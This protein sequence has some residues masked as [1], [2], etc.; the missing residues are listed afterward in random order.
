MKTKEHPTPND[1]RS[2]TKNPSSP[3]Y[4]ADRNNRIQQGHQNIPPPPPKAPSG[5]SGSPKK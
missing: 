2:V 3:P 5:G 4:E 1:Q